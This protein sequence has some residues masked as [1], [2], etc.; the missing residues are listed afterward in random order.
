M[1]LASCLVLVVVSCYE[2][3]IGV[4]TGTGGWRTECRSLSRY[5]RRRQ[6][7]CFKMP[8]R[9]N[10]RGARGCPVPHGTLRAPQLLLRR[11][12]R[13]PGGLTMW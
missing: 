3:L 10:S 9:P 1:M 5:V 2:V 6:V 4:L 11:R 13:G 8:I 7:G 12:S